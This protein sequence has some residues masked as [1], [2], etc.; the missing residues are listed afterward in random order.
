MRQ[1]TVSLSNVGKG[2]KGGGD[3]NALHDV[4]L[5]SERLMKIANELSGADGLGREY[6]SKVPGSYMFFTNS[7]PR[8]DTTSILQH[9]GHDQRG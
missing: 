6:E 8:M 5:I 7:T 9:A 2:R 1:H 4:R 3:S